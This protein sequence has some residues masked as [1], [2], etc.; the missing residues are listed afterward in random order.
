[1]TREVQLKD[2]KLGSKFMFLRADDVFE[3][4]HRDHGQRHAVRSRGHVLSDRHDSADLL[5]ANARRAPGDGR[6]RCGCFGQ[7]G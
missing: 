7:Q 6:G 5:R 3:E 2:L 1:M 4:P